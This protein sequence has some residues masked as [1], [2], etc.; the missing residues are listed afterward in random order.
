VAVIR[1]RADYFTVN[2]EQSLSPEEKVTVLWDAML[3]SKVKIDV[4]F[5]GMCCLLLQV[6]YTL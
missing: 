2:I 1:K 4:H 5:E 6:R 3:F